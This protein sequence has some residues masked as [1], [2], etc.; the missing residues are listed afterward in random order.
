MLEDLRELHGEIY[1]TT[2]PDEVNVPWKPLNYGDYI[3]YT[4]LL[5]EGRI[6][7]ALLEEEIFRKCVVDKG[8]LLKIS[9]GK[10]GT[11]TTVVDHIIKL[12]GPGTIDDFNNLLNVTRS[13]AENPLHKIITV[14]CKAFPAYKPE[15]L[16]VMDINTV[17]LR[18]AQAEGILLEGGLIKEPIVLYKEGEKPK[19]LRRAP[20]ELKSTWEKS[21]KFADLNKAPPPPLKPKTAP[22]AVEGKKQEVSPALVKR[23][24]ID[25]LVIESL[26]K[27][28]TNEYS[29]DPVKRQQMLNDVPTIYADLIERLRQEHEAKQ[30]K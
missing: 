16:Y 24:N 18:L 20:Q 3:Y 8:F 19:P 1:V 6:S 30:K 17:M 23:A 7:R 29:D 27:Q 4:N 25:N 13:I 14:I 10:A 5:Q 11:I 26:N 15:D 22:K 9:G 12:S 2:L 21:M 28:D